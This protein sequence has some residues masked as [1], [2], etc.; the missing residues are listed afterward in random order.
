V[1]TILVIDDD[2]TLRSFLRAV[3]EGAGYAVSEASDGA[4][5]L[6]LFQAAR[7]DLVLCDVYMPGRD[8][9]ATVPELKKLGPDVPVIVMSGGSLTFGDYLKVARQLGA[10]DALDKPF[11][12]DQLLQAIARLLPSREEQG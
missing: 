3:L 10:S 12:Q 9:L 11:R 8:G 1:P 4:A 7:P 2:D 5:G 6:A